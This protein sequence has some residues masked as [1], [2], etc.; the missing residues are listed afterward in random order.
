M[1]RHPRT[2]RRSASV[3]RRSSDP[4]DHLVAQDHRFAQDRL[5]RGAVLPVVQVRAADAAVDDVD[6]RLVRR[7]GGFGP[8]LHPQVAPRV[9]DEPER[10]G[11]HGS[12]G[13]FRW[14]RHGTLP[15]GRSRSAPAPGRTRTVRHRA[16]PGCR[17]RRAPGRDG[18]VGDRGRPDD[19]R[20]TGGAWADRVDRH[21]LEDEQ[22]ARRGAVAGRGVVAGLTARRAA[23][24]AHPALRHP[25]LHRGARGAAAAGRRRRVQG[26]CPEHALG[27]RRRLD[28]R[29]LAPMLRDC[30]RSTWSSSAT[31]NGA[32][33]GETDETVGLKVRAAVDAG[34]RPLVCVGEP[35]AV[36]DAGDEVA[37]VAAQV[38][39]A[40][41]P[42]R[43]DE[44]R[45]CCSRTSRCG[46]SGRHGRRPEVAEVA[47][48]LAE[49]ARLAA[50][51]ARRPR[52]RSC[53]TAAASTWATPRP[54]SPTRRRT[55]SSSAARPGSP[56]GS[57]G[58]SGSRRRWAASEV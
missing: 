12:V 40:L 41:A 58:S 9:H 47:P 57:S 44:R 8:L 31:P 56:R 23:P 50:G 37:F 14:S 24:D 17:G 10:L 38:A 42:V 45:A 48:V 13:S 15:E 54:C 32:L 26:R 43:P 46:R 36:R 22:D 7:R 11:G 2:D 20:G 5:A 30:R 49:V 4:S 35:A 33:F 27:R 55:G 3:R 6:H 52:V 21:Q 29:G 28:R 18:V 51:S 19:G 34:L 39:A 53:S 16:G 25:A 1:D